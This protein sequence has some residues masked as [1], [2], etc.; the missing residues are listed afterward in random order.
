[1]IICVKCAVQLVCDKNEVGA[2]F[3]NG[4]VYASDRFKCPVC[5]IMVL[6]CNTRP[7]Y[8]PDY[9][10]Q[11]EYLNCHEAGGRRLEAVGHAS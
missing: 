4:H 1:M 5:G 3:G 7:H 2:D 9:K 6:N 11:Q 8:D 10:S